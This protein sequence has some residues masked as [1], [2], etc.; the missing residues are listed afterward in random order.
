MEAQGEE[1]NVE[2]AA[3]YSGYLVKI[4]N[5]CSNT[6]QILRVYQFEQSLSHVQLMGP[7]GL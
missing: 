4:M 2:A 6:K 1:A 7:H 3:K 5:E